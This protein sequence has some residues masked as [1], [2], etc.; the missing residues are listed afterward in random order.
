LLALHLCRYYCIFERCRISQSH[1][2]DAVLDDLLRLRELIRVDPNNGAAH[3]ATFCAS[4]LLRSQAQLFQDLLV[5]FLLRG[6]RQGFFVEIGAA[7]GVNLSNTLILERDFQWTGILSEPAYGWHTALKTNRKASI[8]FRFVWSKGGERCEFKETVAR[9]LSTLSSLVNRDFHRDGRVS[10][11]TYLVETISLNE[12]LS[13]YNSPREIDY[14]SI[15]TEG[16]ELAILQ[17]F[18][19]SRY[20]IKII[21]VEHNYVESDREQIK[22]LLTMNNFVR[23]FE[24]LSKFDDWYVQ[25][26]LIGL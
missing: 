20:E 15:D 9:E 21:T 26:P 6:K 8:D 23:I 5:V 19:F 24:P 16:T 11:T 22:Q 18:D 10:G 2:L 14:L 13:E 25:K 3:F 4:N 12:L 7:D 17:A 1:P